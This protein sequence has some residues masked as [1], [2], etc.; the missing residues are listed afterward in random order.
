M[1]REFKTR[2]VKLADELDLYKPRK[3]FFSLEEYRLMTG[4]NG[5]NKKKL[6]Q[7]VISK[8]YGNSSPEMNLF[9]IKYNP[10]RKLARL[11]SIKNSINQRQN[12]FKILNH[13]PDPNY[14]NLLKSINRGK[15]SNANWEQSIN[16]RI[17]N[18]RRNLRG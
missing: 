5:G 8:M 7:Y 15:I 1:N 18:I 11:L 16:R 12:L 6:E 3:D 4:N 10:R 9:R 17:S 2:C 13:S 14:Y